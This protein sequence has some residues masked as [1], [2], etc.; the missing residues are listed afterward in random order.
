MVITRP[1]SLASDIWVR[2]TLTSWPGLTGTLRARSRSAPFSINFT[3]IGIIA[4]GFDRGRD[5]FAYGTL[6]DRLGRRRSRFRLWQVLKPNP[7]EQDKKGLTNRC[8]P[9]NTTV[10]C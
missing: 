2:S 4:T 9:C 6:L 3:L 7:R 10:A 5:E 8:N 1:Y